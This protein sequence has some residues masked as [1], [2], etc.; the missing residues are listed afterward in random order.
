MK[1]RAARVGLLL[2]A[3]T[4]ACAS[5]PAKGQAPTYDTGLPAPPGGGSSSLGAQPGSGFNT[6]GSTPGGGASILSQGAPSSAPLSGRAGPTGPHV[7]SSVSNPGAEAGPNDQPRGITAPIPQPTYSPPSYGSYELPTGPAD[8]GPADGLTLDQAIE[9]LVRENLDLRAKSY[10][11]PQAQA[12]ILNAGL[13]ANPVFYGDGQLIPYGRYNRDRPGGQTQ[14]DANVS[15]PLDLSRKR[16]ARTLY[17]T[18]AKRVIETQY[19]DAV[20]LG[21]DQLYTA[22]VNV[23]AARQTVRYAQA[24]VKGYRQLLDVTNQLYN[25]DQTTRAEVS[26]VS[27]QFETSRV[28]LTDAEEN[29]RKVKR[30]LGALLNV[31]APQAEA[32]EVRG[33]VQDFGPPPPP[34]AELVPMALALRPDVVAYRLGI[35]TAEANVR[36]QKANRFSDVY[37][38]YQPYTFQDNSPFGLKSPTSWALGVT[39]PLPV[40]NRNQG[41]IARAKLN[42]VQSQIE[43]ANVERQT[44]TDVQQALHEYQVTARMVERISKTIRPAA[45]Q[46]RDDTYRLFQGGEINVV[47]YL[48]AQREYQDIVKQYLDTVVRHRR[49]MLALNTVVGQR[50]LP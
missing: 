44:V 17:A 34:E 18:R 13:R 39:V 7:P 36:L 10:E 16:Q 30:D 26:R 25:R 5:G 23:L 6:M 12:D 50:V 37:V 21:I 47:D 28:G 4:W 38:L 14:Y 48:R 3:V 20:R 45:Q 29:L 22:Y 31:P 15:Y 1:R 43:L 46:V 49:A 24:S 9:R 19:Q 27:V 11:I 32:L 40:Y 42:V 2:C 33:S 41:G 35:R 8:D